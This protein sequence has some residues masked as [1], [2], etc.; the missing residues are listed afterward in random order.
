MERSHA[1][2]VSEMRLALLSEHGARAI[3]RDLAR[4]A[5][6]R[7]LRQVLAQLALES[8]AQVGELERAMQALGGRQP[9]GSLRRTLLARTLAA[10]S[11]ILGRRL[12]LRICAQAAD[13]AARWYAYFQ[14]YLL[15][16]GEP[17]LASR[18]GRMSEV[19]RRHARLL[20]TW[21]WN[22]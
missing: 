15:R 17:E 5:P 4:R 13:R 12:V 2:L 7:E 9:R 1:R 19:R 8:D 6:P 18:C 21:V 3:Y 22:A 11:P 20:E 16:I 14:L 10:A